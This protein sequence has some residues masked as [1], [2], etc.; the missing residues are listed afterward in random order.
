MQYATHSILTSKCQI[1]TLVYICIYVPTYYTVL[2]TY[3][4]KILNIQTKD[5][6]IINTNALISI[7]RYQI[8]PYRTIILPAYSPVVPPLGRIARE[9]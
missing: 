2:R 5:K 6:T 7:K 8:G 3:Q 1:Q 4:H 9:P